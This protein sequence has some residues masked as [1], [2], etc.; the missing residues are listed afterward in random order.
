MRI[1]LTITLI[2]VLPLISKGQ[3]AQTLSSVCEQVS[4]QWKLDSTS[5]GGNRLRLA[6]LFPSARPDSISK[7]F[8]F[9]TLGKPNSIQ[10]YYVGYPDGKRYV[11]YIY[12]IYKDDCPKIHARGAAIG[13][14]FDESESYFIR[15]EEHEYCG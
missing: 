14:V 12:F 7:V 13:F 9:S 11:E 1:I 15:I 10:R 6:R 8:L 2:I 5:C 3:W 4:M